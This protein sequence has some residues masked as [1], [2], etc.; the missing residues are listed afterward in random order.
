MIYSSFEENRHNA[1]FDYLDTYLANSETGVNRERYFEICERMGDT[2]D[3]D[4]IP[5]DISDFPHY[6]ISGV[7]IFNDLTDTYIG[8]GMSAPIYSGK[9]LSALMTLLSIYQVR[10]DEHLYV[11]DVIKFLDARARKKAVRD[12]KRRNKR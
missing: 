9:D 10:E 2:P 3:P 6:V 12:A 4:K 5:P 7:K 1:V 8:G 11:L